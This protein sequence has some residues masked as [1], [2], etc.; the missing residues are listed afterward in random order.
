MMKRLCFLAVITVALVSVR[1]FAHFHHD[2]QPF[3][4]SI[5]DKIGFMDVNCRMVIPPQY[6]EAFG[7]N[8]GLAAVKMGDKWGYIDR[9]G[10]TVIRPRFALAWAFS[11]GL[12]SVKLEETSALFGFIDKS[13]RI[14]IE[15]QFGMPLTFSEGLVEGY[16]EENKILNVP[17]GYVNS[18][19]EYV[20]RLQEPGKEI[21]FLTVSQRDLQG[22]RCRYNIRTEA[23]SRVSGVS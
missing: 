23:S 16:G 9:N 1:A 17:L 8:E 18:S 20:I 5:G 4:V 11:D 21:E 6:S 10:A 19:G 12:A 2:D 22:F 7:F 13:G 14:V 15:P 3:L